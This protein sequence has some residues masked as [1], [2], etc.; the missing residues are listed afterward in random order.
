MQYNALSVGKKTPQ[1]CPFPLGFCHPA[2]RKRAT[3]IGNTHRKIGKDRTCGFGDIVAD[4]QTNT[5]TDVL[6]TILR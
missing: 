5:H 1:N 2:G 4:R 3:V 6:I